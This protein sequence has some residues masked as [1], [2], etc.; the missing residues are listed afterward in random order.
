[1]TEDAE[2]LLKEF[3]SGRFVRPDWSRPNPVSLARD[4]SSIGGHY[5]WADDAVASEIRTQIGRPDHVVLIIGDGFGMN[6]VNSLPEE[7]FSRSHLTWEQPA[8]FP[9]GTG[10]NMTSLLSG[11]WPGQHGFIGWWVYLPQ[12][13][14]RSTVLEWIRA[15]DGADLGSLGVQPEEVFLSRPFLG[16]LKVD[17]LYVLPAAYAGSIPTRFSQSGSSQ[18]QGFKSLASAMEIVER[19]VL[20]ASGR[21]FTLLYWSEIDAVAHKHGVKAP[22]TVQG[23]LEFD[24]AIGQLAV[25]LN[26]KARIIVTADHGH[27]DV[28][29]FVQLDPGHALA[30][31]L[32]CTQSGDGRVSHFHVREGEHERF[33]VEF[34]K[35]FGESFFLIN[36]RDVIDMGLFGP[37]PLA[38]VVR[39]RLGDFTAIS[40][41]GAFLGSRSPGDRTNFLRSAHGGLS[42]DEMMVPFILA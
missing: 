26:R 42:P 28:P 19:R 23:V 17:A 11:E 15:S 12:I 39:V 35:M 21:T 1:M 25:A 27:L 37:K 8:V 34:T 6:F 33:A 7:S 38:D 13:G 41:S 10:P 22:A 9:S 14:E 3:E 24:R 36:S 32:K 16:S 30:R 5:D 4:V 40:R 29:K 2:S 31:L 20:D 18:R